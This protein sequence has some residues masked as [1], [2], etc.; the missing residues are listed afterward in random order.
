MTL[1]YTASKKVAET[2]FSNRNNSKPEIDFV[3]V[4]T[5]FKNVRWSLQKSTKAPENFPPGGAGR[6]RNRKMGISPKFSIPKMTHFRRNDFFKILH[7]DRG[8][9]L[10]VIKEVTRKFISGKNVRV[11]F[12]DFGFGGP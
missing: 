11:D 5:A 1:S 12:S 4:P 10:L 2:A 9:I 7:I 8:P 3:P 6:G